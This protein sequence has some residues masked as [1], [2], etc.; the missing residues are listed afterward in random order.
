MSQQQQQQS[1]EDRELSLVGKVEM[2]IA[3]AETDAK[4]E[5]LLTTYLAP[6]LLKLASDHQAVRNKVVGICHHVNTRIRPMK[7]IQLPIPALLKQFKDTESSLVKEFDLIYIRQGLER[8]DASQRSS[9]LPDLLSGS[10]NG[11]SQRQDSQMFNLVLRLL[12]SFKLP[13]RGSN[14]ESKLREELRLSDADAAF[15]SK[16]FAKL[17]LLVPFGRRPQEATSY[18]GLTPTEFSFLNRDAPP[19]EAWDPSTPA[20]LNLAETKITVAKFLSSAAFR[21]NERFL[22]AVIMS[23][24]ADNRVSQVGEDIFRHSHFDM[25][26]TMFIEQ[27]YR[28]YLGY[29][30]APPA[31]PALQIRIL[32]RLSNSVYAANQTFYIKEIIRRTLGDEEERGGKGLEGQKLRSQI[33][34]FINWITRMGSASTLETLAPF[35]ISGLRGFLMGQGWPN[36]DNIPH[37]STPDLHAR[38]LAYESIGI[39][40]AKLKR[41]PLSHEGIN[42]DLELLQ[43][44]LRSLGS[45]ISS[46]QIPV[47]IDQGL[48]NLLNALASSYNPA[49]ES[50]GESSMIL[51]FQSQLRGIL[52]HHM[53]LKTGV[54]DPETKWHK[55]RST[56]YAVLR[57]ANRCLP[58]SDVR[59]RWIDLMAAGGATSG[60]RAE[61]V[62]E[63]QKGL[64]PYWYRMLNPPKEGSWI[65]SSDSLASNYQ[66]PNF[67]DL[68]TFLFGDSADQQSHLDT[69]LPKRF[70]SQSEGLTAP[71]GASDESPY[72]S[73]FTTSLPPA[74]AFAQHILISEALSLAGTPPNVDPDWSN[75]LDTRLTTDEHTRI[76]VRKYLSSCDRAAAVSF[77]NYSLVGFL[78]VQEQKTLQP[79]TLSGFARCGDHFI[80]MCSLSSN[81]LLYPL[82]NHVTSSS[83]TD[84]VL[85]NDLV[86]QDTASRIYG[87]LGSLPA[88]DTGFHSREI[89]KYVSTVSTWKSTVG[90]ELNRARGALLSSA[91]LV[92]RMA[93]RGTL[94]ALPKDLI[95]K[96]IHLV[97]EILIDSRDLS[98]R[99]GAHKS[100][101]QLSLA[102]VVNRYG[103]FDGGL[104]DSHAI[105]EKLLSDGKREKDSAVLG[106]GAFSLVFPS[107][108]AEFANVLSSMYTLHE[109]RRPEIQFSVG[110]ALCTIALGWASKALIYTFDIDA[111][112]PRSPIPENVLSDMLEKILTDCKASKLS[113]RKAS[114]IWLLCLVQ[115]CGHHDIIQQKLRV[116]QSTFVWLLS[117]RDDIVQE[118]GSRGLSLVYEMG[119]QDLK[120]DLVR[121]LVQSFTSGEENSSNNALRGGKV[122]N[123]TE[124]FEP[125]ALP[126]GGGKS[127]TTYKDIVG[128][129][130]EVGDPSL[131]YRFMS[132]ASNN[133]IWSSRAAFGRFGL[134]NVLSDSSV[135]GYLSQNPKLYP[136]LYRYRFDPNPNVQRSMTDIWNALVKD[137]NAVIEANFDAIISDLLK[138]ILAGKEWRVRQASCAAIADLLQG[139]Q[140]EKY[141]QYL[142]EILTKAFKVLDD[143]KETVRAAAMKLCQTLI[144]IVIRVLEASSP[145]DSRRSRLMLDHVVPF[146]LGT[147]GLESSSEEVQTYATTALIRI[148]KKSPGRIIR[149]YATS[150]AER[151]LSSLSSM[152]PQMVNYVQLNADKYGL[153]G[154]KIDRMRLSAIQSSPMME[155]IELYLLDAITSENDEVMAQFANAL[156]NALRSAIGLPS[157]VGVSR[158]VVNLCSK[159]LLFRPYSDRFMML[160]RKYV[161]DVNDTV[162]A[163]YSSCLGYLTRLA[164]QEEIL[165]TL[166][167]AQSTYLATNSTDD[168]A[169][170]RQVA[171]EVIH[172]MSKYGSDAMSKVEAAFLPFVFV[173]KHDTDEYV[174]REFADIWSEHVFGTRAVTS[175]F[176]TEI[177]RLISHTADSPRWAVKHASAL[178]LATL[179][180]AFDADA[181]IESDKAK[182][183]W[184]VLEHA[185]GGKTWDG[186]EKV[187]DGF[188]QFCLKTQGFREEEG[189]VEKQM[190]VSALYGKFEQV[191]LSRTG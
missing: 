35:A 57:F 126:T 31:R 179:I 6:L 82:A 72:I 134:S 85:S 178:S 128:L 88:I 62:E 91:S 18:P 22:A 11:G 191:A 30:G 75:V 113:L 50:T 121:D 163:A 104:H 93:I 13:P 80:N 19:A 167:F 55:I 8:L 144:N 139:R 187:L 43:W 183:I 165:R 99:D 63:G 112:W 92:S 78:Q 67:I 27:L 5:S 89:E 21:D 42:N 146:L 46:G 158:V 86:T 166:N 157:K 36:P 173:A 127:V 100:L 186:K 51:L 64:D 66:P 76:A 155:A 74:I 34:T 52:L 84:A 10:A 114:A 103:Y 141:E 115:Y 109:I 81:A 96:L 33:F 37:F 188:V 176:L 61:V 174:R 4:L 132:L 47:S 53:S 26:D 131:V 58:Y 9:L 23:A 40:S 60:D 182:V 48:G 168:N 71:A 90:Q 106:L 94:D 49:S 181:C 25:E 28:L 156:E 87:I 171:G 119:T 29:N 2:R 177:V 135:N 1:P 129:A 54:V 24:D 130:S 17:L 143:I 38:G 140:I 154:D 70:T 142:T 108:S 44:F 116:C 41:S 125:G 150:I 73:D 117:D 12:S 145:A 164:S 159:T 160:M 138:S 184:P 101:S 149:P 110:E 16:W 15:Y 175:L 190:T 162:S 39:L 59:A 3:L 102:N 147:G 137:S 123:E 107:D 65:V 180:G 111:E 69:L 20:G 97:F 95:F 68:V 45:D 79:T 169:R 14:E 120:D 122:S 151:F 153:T 148:I 83:L 77:L 7:S 172:A 189:G 161:L 133:A 98:L 152:E 136:K 118:T 32:A 170:Q 56:R 105:V 185:I 124:L